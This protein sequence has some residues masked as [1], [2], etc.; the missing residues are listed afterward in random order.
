MS[1]L[2]VFLLTELCF[3]FIITCFFYYYL[4]KMRKDSCSFLPSSNISDH[5]LISPYFT[6][7]LCS[8]SKS[9]REPNQR[10]RKV[11]RP[12]TRSTGTPEI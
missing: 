8:F 6:L 5:W 9:G 2:S 7:I 10:K 11:E 4:G 1:V 3:R 12:F